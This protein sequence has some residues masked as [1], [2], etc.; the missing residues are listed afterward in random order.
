MLDRPVQPALA[1]L[2]FTVVSVVP[3]ALKRGHARFEW[4]VNDPPERQPARTGA[5]ADPR[6][7]AIAAAGHR[8][9]EHRDL[10]NLDVHELAPERAA[11]RIGDM[12]A[13]Y[14]NR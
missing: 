1:G 3:P 11:H 6:A 7:E 13:A 4:D 8:Q 12:R 14:P 10:Q 5:H 2:Q 9:Q